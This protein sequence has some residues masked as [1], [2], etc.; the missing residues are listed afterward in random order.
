MPTQKFTDLCGVGL[1]VPTF[2]EDEFNVA[3]RVILQT[4]FSNTNVREFLKKLTVDSIAPEVLATVKDNLETGGNS[5]G[6]RMTCINVT[7]LNMGKHKTL[8]FNP[9]LQFNPELES[10]DFAHKIQHVIRDLVLKFK[11][12]KY[13]LQLTTKLLDDSFITDIYTEI[14]TPPPDR[15]YMKTM[16]YVDVIFEK[17]TTV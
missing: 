1:S 3:K 5:W 7:K 8:H 6:I 14:V 16:A 2:T 4:Y 13:D 10:S 17:K 11:D 9:A 12:D 15:S